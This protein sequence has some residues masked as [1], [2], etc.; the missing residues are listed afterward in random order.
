MVYWELR[1]GGYTVRAVNPHATEV[2]GDRAWPRLADLP[3]I[4]DVVNFVTPPTVTTSVVDEALRLGI[5]RLWFQPGSEDPAALARARVAG[6]VVIRACAMTERRRR[7]ARP[8]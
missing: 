2:E 4:P 6:A 1:A 3:E 8:L 7:G 5:R